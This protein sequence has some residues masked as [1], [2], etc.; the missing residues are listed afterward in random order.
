MEHKDLTYRTPLI[1][2]QDPEQHW[3]AGLSE[4]RKSTQNHHPNKAGHVFKTG[5]QGL[6]EVAEATAAGSEPFAKPDRCLNG[7]W[8]RNVL[9]PEI[10]VEEG[11]L[12][13]VSKQGRSD[14]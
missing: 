4:L 13:G 1:L 12:V 7:T 8:P 9:S 10:E 2:G 3:C 5:P 6:H 11:H 14:L